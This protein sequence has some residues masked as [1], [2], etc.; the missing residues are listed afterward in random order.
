MAAGPMADTDL[1]TNSKRIARPRVHEPKRARVMWLASD[2]ESSTTQAAFLASESTSSATRSARRT[3]VS[4]R[5]RSLRATS[6][7][8]IIGLSLHLKEDR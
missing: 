8:H 7:A 3:G 1:E 4:S 5:L 6:S 2:A